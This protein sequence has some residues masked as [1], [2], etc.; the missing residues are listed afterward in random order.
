MKT[1]TITP[2]ISEFKECLN[3]FFSELRKADYFARQNFSCCQS[4]GWAQIPTKTADKAVFYTQQDN[5]DIT[6]MR[7]HV[8]WSG[9]GSEICR[10]ARSKGLNV[11]WN[12]TTRK[13]I[14]LTP[15]QN[16]ADQHDKES[17]RY[18]NNEVQHGK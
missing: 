16:G 11:L 1:K 15:K 8:S 18:Q 17:Q 12:G 14:L 13:R 2:T 7:L 5:A 9:N 6:K 4:C 10:I 3:E